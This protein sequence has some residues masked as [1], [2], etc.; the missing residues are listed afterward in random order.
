[1]RRVSILGMITIV[2]VVMTGL[3]VKATL[4]E[5]EAK[6][7][8]TLEGIGVPETHQCS[9]TDPFYDRFSQSV[10]VQPKSSGAITAYCD[11][12]DF[13]MGGGYNMSTS[14]IPPLPALGGMNVFL[15]YRGG[16]GDSWFVQVYNIAPEVNNI[17][18]RVVCARSK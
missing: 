12:G 11:A 17:E 18:A 3:M 14:A 15:S 2:A 9:E 13:A 8:N 5:V 6:P 4:G 10:P 16:G 7:C 1:M